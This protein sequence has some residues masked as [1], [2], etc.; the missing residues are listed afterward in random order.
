MRAKPVV[1]LIVALG[2]GM[3]A[4]VAASK[5]VLNQG[6][7]QAEATVEIFVAVKDLE[8][9]QRMSAENVRLDRWPKSRLPE[10]ALV[11]LEQLEDK[12]TNQVIFAG[13]PILD[14]KL[15]DSRESFSTG[16]PPGFRIFNIAG[17]SSVVYI[18]PGDHVDILGTF[19]LGGRNAVAESAT[20]MRN[21]KVHG[22]NGVTIR[23]S[24]ENN[25]AKNTTFQLLVKESQ[26]ETLTLANKLGELQL[27]LRPFGEEENE[28]R[29][30]NGDAFMNWISENE[31]PEP[32]AVLTSIT[33][34]LIEAPEEPTAKHEMAVITPNGVVRWQ[35][36]DMNSLPTQVEEKSQTNKQSLGA[37]SNSDNRGAASSNVSSGYGGYPP[38]YPS[39][40]E[41]TQLS[42]GDQARGEGEPAP[43]V[44]QRRR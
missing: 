35:W 12:F 36:N 22:I 28:G 24:D 14:R 8:H 41:E 10:G 32:P 25:A 9:L 23:D 13:E 11:K 34:P 30:D 43:S 31:K 27:N 33:S 40:D 19:Q 15:V 42:G 39:S 4:A 3:V 38:T 16:I 21:V 20:V 7:D 18:K 5:A 17:G 6:P 29:P 26:L 1:L 37:N 2:C 44:I